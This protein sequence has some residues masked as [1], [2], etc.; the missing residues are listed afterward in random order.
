MYFLFDPKKIYENNEK[1]IFTFTS[2]YS[3]KKNR[4][5]VKIYIEFCG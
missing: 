4:M 5:I 2:K 3:H 1:T